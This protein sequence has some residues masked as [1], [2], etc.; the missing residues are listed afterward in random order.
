MV[1]NNARAYV[2]FLGRYLQADPLGL[3]SGSLNNYVYVGNNP[4]NLVDP[5]GLCFE[6]ACVGEAVLAGIAIRAAV[7]YVARLGVA[8]AGWFALNEAKAPEEV[9]SDTGANT[10]GQVCPKSGSSGGDGAGK[11]FS[12]KIKE[13]AREESGDTCV[14]C[15][16]K[17]SSDPS[18]ERSEIDHAIPKS[19]GGNNTINNA[20][21]TC[22]TCNRQKGAKT[23]EE[24]LNKIIQGV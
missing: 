12:K 6:D 2:P 16:T 14:F 3:A 9:A 21:N 1:Y 19:R 15:G 20:Q 24:F 10:T 7:P 13:L 4:V 11:G 5:S 8:M 22:R 23:T 18:P 17:T